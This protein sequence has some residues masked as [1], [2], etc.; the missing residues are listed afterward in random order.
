ML[1]PATSNLQYALLWMYGTINYSCETISGGL[2]LGMSMSTVVVRCTAE[3]VKD[4]EEY[5]SKF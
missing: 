2:S 3:S 4:R 1:L 5:F